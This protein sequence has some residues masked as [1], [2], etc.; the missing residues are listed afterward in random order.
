MSPSSGEQFCAPELDCV[1]SVL[2]PISFRPFQP[3]VFH[4]GD[5]NRLPGLDRQ[6]EHSQVVTLVVLKRET[7]Q[8]SE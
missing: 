3:V 8:R 6:P 1:E 5:Q 2:P 4:G 7:C